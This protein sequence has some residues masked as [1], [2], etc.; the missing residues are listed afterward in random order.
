[1][2][3]LKIILLAFMIS[4]FGYALSDGIPLSCATIY[5]QGGSPAILQS[6]ECRHW[7]L[8]KGFSD[9]QTDLNC[10]WG[11]GTLQRHKISGDDHV[12]C[13]LNMEIPFYGQ[14]NSNDA[15]FGMVAVFDHHGLE[16]LSKTASKVLKELFLVHVYFVWDET[17]ASDK[18]REVPCKNEELV[19]Q[20]SEAKRFDG[21]SSSEFDHTTLK[22]ILRE[23]LLRTVRDLSSTFGGEIDQNNLVLGCPTIS[24]LVKGQAL[25]VDACNSR[26]FLCRG[27]PGSTNYGDTRVK[28]S[29]KE[30][31]QGV[32]VKEDDETPSWCTL[33]SDNRPILRRAN[34]SLYLKR[35]GDVGAVSVSDWQALTDQDLFWW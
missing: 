4:L 12:L 34:S 9:N 32:T 27:Q 6:P 20:N 3:N 16:N 8:S 22:M 17:Y 30:L 31:T 21:I 10:Y 24:I 7:V 2:E 33:R 18:C 19:L 35:Y 29:A 28:Y 13:D 5:K 15:R 25:V 14:N 1:M 11:T 26:A 23:A